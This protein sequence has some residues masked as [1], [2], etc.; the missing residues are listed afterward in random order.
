MARGQ[1]PEHMRK[2]GPKKGEIRNPNGLAKG[3][4][5]AATI[6]GWLFEDDSIETVLQDPAKA[7]EYCRKMG[8]P[9]KLSRLQLLAAVQYGKALKG[10]IKS[11]EFLM[12][13]AIGKPKASLTIEGNPDNPMVIHHTSDDAEI[14][15]RYM[16]SNKNV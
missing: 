3:T 8:V 5:T 14:L 13:R 16:E 1:S 12:D 2:I 15:K 9:K 6:F 11:A 10:D 7:E 4:Q